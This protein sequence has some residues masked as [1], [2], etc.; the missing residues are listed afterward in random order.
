MRKMNLILGLWLC[1]TAQ[2]NASDIGS[3]KCFGGDGPNP[4]TDITKIQNLGVT[5]FDLRGPVHEFVFWEKKNQIVY[6][7]QFGKIYRLD[8]R[9]GKSVLLG[10][11]NASLSPVK[12][13]GERYITLVGS[14]ITLD[15][16]TNPPRWQKWSHKKR[17]KHLYWHR[18]FGR[19]S[20]F[21][22]TSSIVRPHQ[23]QIEVYSFSQKGSSH[24]SV[25]S[26]P[27]WEKYFT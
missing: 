8:L 20:L 7:N 27:V 1:V 24:I 10:S 11:S 22:V 21:S 2:I 12:D 26:T 25:T 3:I 18:F 16:A 23:Q 19:D 17:V 6:R 13:P 9:S 15:T 14:P 4:L 5:N